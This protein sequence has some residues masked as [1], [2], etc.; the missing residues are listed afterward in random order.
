M[1]STD[2][3]NQRENQSSSFNS[4]QMGRKNSQLI[5]YCFHLFPRFLFYK[6][7][8][9]NSIHL[10]LLVKDVSDGVMRKCV[11][12]ISILANTGVCMCNEIDWKSF[13]LSTMNANAHCL[14]LPIPVQGHI[15]PMLQF[16]KRLTHKRIR[17]T[18]ALT[19]FILKTT[20]FSS[21]SISVRAISDGFD[22]GGRAQ[23]KSSDEYLARFQ[24]MGQQTLAELLQDLQG[25]GCPVDCVIYDPFIPWVLD[26]AKRFGLM[27]AA[28]F[29]QSCAVDNIYY[30]VYAGEIK[31]PFHGGEVVVP[32]LPPM[33]PEEMPSFIYNHGSYP[34]TFQMV[35]NQF[36]NIDKADWIFI[37]TFDKLEEQVTNLNLL[38]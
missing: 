19:K 7:R 25:S 18:F 26:V 38:P 33:K 37:N 31:L 12:Y 14:I 8:N 6:H 13:H 11:F 17:V 10:F 24:Q 28:F 21:G 3:G 4:L 5:L 20:S 34:G 30:Q 23:A 36:R 9:R 1:Y 29:T 35:L 27:A 16:A 22:E 15:N 32:G 2:G